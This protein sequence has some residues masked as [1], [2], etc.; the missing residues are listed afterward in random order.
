VRRGLAWLARATDDGRQFRP[1][2]IG[3]YFAR[4]WYSEELYPLVFTAAACEI[5][6]ARGWDQ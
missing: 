1:S 3:L 6:A 4:L 2:P 5:A